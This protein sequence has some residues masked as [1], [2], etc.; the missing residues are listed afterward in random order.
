[1]LHRTH[2]QDLRHSLKNSETTA[3]T[4]RRY[5]AHDGK[6]RC[7]GVPAALKASQC[8]PQW[9]ER[10]HARSIYRHVYCDFQLVSFLQPDASSKCDCDA[11]FQW[12]TYTP[13][14]GAGVADMVAN[15][16]C[17]KGCKGCS[18]L[19]HEE[20][21]TDFYNVELNVKLLF[22]KPMGDVWEDVRHQTLDMNTQSACTI[23]H[24]LTLRFRRLT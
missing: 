10:L 12:R 2:D 8:M 19:L 16:A 5:I 6:R 13:E 23:M 14:F 24:T 18:C 3:K 17:S 7:V 1:M 4:T 21:S 20:A 9:I 15:A 11:M 22:E